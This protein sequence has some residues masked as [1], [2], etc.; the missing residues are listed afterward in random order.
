M[1]VIKTTIRGVDAV[2]PQSR[3]TG[4]KSTLEQ[5]GQTPGCCPACG[6]VVDH[7][8]NGIRLI[9]D[10][11]FCG[12]MF[13]ALRPAP[14]K[15]LGLMLNACGMVVTKEQMMHELYGMDPNGGPDDNKIVD[16]FVYWLRKKLK[17]TGVPLEILT[18][19]GRGYSVRMTGDE[20]AKD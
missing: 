20:A 5:K 19:W 14:S 3:R 6:S 7:E 8:A 17:G 2:K 4:W 15:L 18:W 11:L 1:T 10:T 9:G 12:D 13:V 16:I